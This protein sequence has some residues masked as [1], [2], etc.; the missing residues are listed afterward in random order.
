MTIN[1]LI[2]IPYK[3]HG[4]DSREG[5]DCWGLAI[6]IYRRMG[7]TLPDY[8][9]DTTDTASNVKTGE[10]IF[11]TV[12][13]TKLEKPEPWCLI[14]L[15]IL[16]EPSHVGIYLGSGDFIHASKKTGVAVD[17]IFRWKKRIAGYYRI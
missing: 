2:G 1:D 15:T 17:K 11:A 9:Y 8:V 10:R 13:T 6:E 12:P 14:E 3:P 16:G 4:R 5:L 7:K